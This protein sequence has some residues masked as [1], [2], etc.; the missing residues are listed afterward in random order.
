MQIDSHLLDRV[1][2]SF[3]VWKRTV[4]LLINGWVSVVPRDFHSEAKTLRP[5]AVFIGK[6]NSFDVAAS[7][8]KEICPDIIRGSRH[9][10]G[11]FVRLP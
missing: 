11:V 1:G 5:I 6:L 7:H 4:A 10:C 8:E 2:P 9:L 3:L